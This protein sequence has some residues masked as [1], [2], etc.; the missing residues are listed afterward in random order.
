MLFGL[1]V[2]V[3]VKL[4]EYVPSGKLDDVNAIVP[5]VPEQVVGL[6][7]VPTVNTGKAKSTKAT[8]VANEPVQPLPLVIEKLLYVPSAKPESVKAP[9]VIVID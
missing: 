5:F 9:E 7:D 1:A 3:V 4:K 6:L 8:G 2:P